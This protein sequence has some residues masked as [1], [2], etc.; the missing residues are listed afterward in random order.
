MGKWVSGESACYASIKNWAQIQHKTVRHRSVYLEL[1]SG[2][3]QIQL[4]PGPASLA[5]SMSSGFRESAC[6]TQNQT[7]TYRGRHEMLNCPPRGLT[8]RTRVHIFLH[9]HTPAEYTNHLKRQDSSEL[10]CWIT[11]I[12]YRMKSQMFDQYHSLWWGK[13]KKKGKK[14]KLT[15]QHIDSQGCIPVDWTEATMSDLVS[16]CCCDKHLDQMWLKGGK[17][18]LCLFGLHT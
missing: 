10:L 6:L 16:F 8:R 13:R 2:G 4:A 7:E 12:N 11:S 3:K 17:V 1:Q 5:K 14:I 9:V 15:G 18:A